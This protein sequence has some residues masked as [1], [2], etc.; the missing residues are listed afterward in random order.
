MIS[1]NIKYDKIVDNYIHI[2]KNKKNKLDDIVV[3]NNINNTDIDDE[4]KYYNYNIDIIKDIIFS[5]P[6][7]YY[8]DILIIH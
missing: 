1:Y 3:E 8:D 6:K 4:K 5:L 7:K 2:S